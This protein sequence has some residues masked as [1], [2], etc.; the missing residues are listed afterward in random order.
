MIDIAAPI[1]NK[2]VEP[3]SIALAVLT[4]NQ[5][6]IQHIFNLFIFQWYYIDSYELLSFLWYEI[7]YELYKY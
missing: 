1:I 4:W 7:N 3:I 5:H 6:I 2:T